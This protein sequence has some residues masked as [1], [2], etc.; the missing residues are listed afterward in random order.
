MGKIWGGDEEDMGKI[1]GGDEE[2]M[3]RG[4]G[5]DEEDMG[6]GRG[7]RIWTHTHRNYNI[8]ILTCMLFVLGSLW[9]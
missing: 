9:H 8:N 7:G 4:W 2:D 3:G 6:R 5:G 1:W